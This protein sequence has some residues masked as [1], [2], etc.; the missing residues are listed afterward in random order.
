MRTTSQPLRDIARRRNLALPLKNARI[1]VSKSQR[2][3]ELFDGNQLGENLSCGTGLAAS[4]TQAMAGRWP[5]SRRPILH[6]HAQCA[7][8]C[9]SHLSWSQLSGAA[10]C[11]TGRAEQGDNG[12]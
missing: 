2:R 10:R 7:D 3:L 8:F 6:L 5:H 1:V 4:G 12:A 11:H 9:F